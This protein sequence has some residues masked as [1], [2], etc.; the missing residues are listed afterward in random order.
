M[1]TFW[2]GIGGS[3]LQ[4]APRARS[5]GGHAAS[6]L[7]QVAFQRGQR[8]LAH[9]PIVSSGKFHRFASASRNQFPGI[10]LVVDLGGPGAGGAFTR[11]AVVLTGQRNTKAL[12]VFLRMDRTGG[13]QSGGK[14]PGNAVPFSNG[15]RNRRD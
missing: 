7:R 13:G 1:V 4:G 12:L 10:A 8:A 9:H 15:R 5:A 3:P 14:R 2:S 11:G 6:R